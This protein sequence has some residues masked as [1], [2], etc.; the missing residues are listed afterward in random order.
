[1]S[2]LTNLLSA[3]AT[4]RDAT[5][6]SENTASRIGGLFVSIIQTLID[7]M[8]EAQIDGTS[9]SYQVSDSNFIIS[10]KKMLDDGTEIPFKIVIPAA[11]SVYAGLLTPASLN[12]INE[13]SKEIERIKSGQTIV[14]VAQKV[15]S[16]AIFR[17]FVGGNNILPLEN[18]AFYIANK[19][20]TIFDAEGN[21][22]EVG[23]GVTMILRSNAQWKVYP[24]WILADSLTD[25]SPTHFLSAKQ[26]YVLKR[27]I[28]QLVA[29]GDG[30]GTIPIDGKLSLESI[31]P[32]QNAVI[33]SAIYRL[34][35]AVF[36]LEV[37]LSV[38]PSGAQEYTGANKEFTISWTIKIAGES[39]APSELALTVGGTIVEID[40]KT[41]TSVTVV[42]DD[43]RKVELYVE[44]D[45]RSAIKTANINFARRYY[46]A[47][48]D[49]GWSATDDTI[50]ALAK[51][52][53][54]SA[55]AATVTY[56]AATQKKIVF[57]YPV[58]HGLMSTIKDAYGNSMFALND[59][60]KTFNTAPKTVAVTLSGGATLDYYVYES[61]ITNVT[62]GN[63]TYTTKSFD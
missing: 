51:S 12:K 7:T 15:S 57:A 43:D 54:K 55:A 39:V 62:A 46:S 29:F 52:A 50:K 17:G 58:S 25:Q 18:N 13:N 40:D 8:P 35:R 1:M 20:A 41:K 32:V 10:M 60:G 53:L 34:E 21:S 63:I 33:T 24:F 9:L 22:I 36:P 11:S 44:A 3:A 56:S 31:H 23:D 6:E 37:T 59:S 14:P 30:E 4:V 19:T 2:K 5:E 45:G 26:G 38:Y 28:D 47:V 16:G 48:V 49:S 42:A 27:M 61:A